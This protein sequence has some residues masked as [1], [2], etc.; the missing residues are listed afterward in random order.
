LIYVDSSVILAHVLAE[1]RHPSPRLWERDL[2]ASRLAEYECWVRLHA[3]GRAE[4]EGASLA[5]TLSRL[6][7]VALDDVACARARSPFP[8]PV[9]TL[10]ALH[11]AAADFMRSRGFVLAFATYDERLGRAAE[12]LG[13]A[14]CGGELLGP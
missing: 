4:S 14:R 12:S 10:D 5:A 8:V 9:R 2:V 1:G 3:Y 13:F 7:L 6:D 11:L